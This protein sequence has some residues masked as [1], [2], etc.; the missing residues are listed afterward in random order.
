MLEME[1][2]SLKGRDMLKKLAEVWGAL[3]EEE[4]DEY[5]TG[6][7]TASSTTSST[8]ASSTDVT[9]IPEEVEEVDVQTAVAYVRF[10]NETQPEMEKIY[11][12]VDTATILQ[13][14]NDAWKKMPQED[15]EEYMSM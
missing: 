3:T 4:Q 15:R 13:L 6:G 7:A 1:Y 10:I 2:P 9:E 5:E 8:S 14:M 11:K 12:G